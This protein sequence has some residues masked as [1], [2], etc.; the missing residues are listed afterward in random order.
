MDF[1]GILF[2]SATIVSLI[3]NYIQ[4]LKRKNLEKNLRTYLQAS[5]NQFKRIK[6]FANK[7]REAKPKQTDE[8]SESVKSWNLAMFG[9][10][11]ASEISISSFMREHLKCI[12]RIEE[13]DKPSPEPLEKVN[14]K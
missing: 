12:P 9:H 11:E 13:P 10:A 4:Y 14:K 2:G 1:W 8:F 5:F 6:A 3:I 7:I